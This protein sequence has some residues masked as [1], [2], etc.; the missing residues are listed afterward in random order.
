MITEQTD[1]IISGA[2][3]TGCTLAA[4]LAKQGISS[5]IIESSNSAFKSSSARKDPRILSLT[6][7]TKRILSSIDIWHQLPVGKIGGFEKIHIWDDDT[8]ADIVFNCSDVCAPALG[9]IVGQAVLQEVLE[10]LI[11][12]IPIINTMTGVTIA[13]YIEDDGMIN[14]ELSD[15]RVIKSRLLVGADGANSQI[16]NLAGIAVECIDYHQKAVA[17][18]VQTQIPHDKIARQRFLSTGPLAFLPMHEEN[19]CGVVWSTQSELADAL[20][21]LDDREFCLALEEAFESRL[22][23]VQRCE[24]RVGFK[25]HRNQALSYF[26]R[27]CVLVGDAAHTVHPLAGQGAN[28]GITD[29]AVLSQLL[30][31]AK[32]DDRM[33]VS[34]QV[35]RNYERWRKTEN[36]KMTLI[37]EGLKNFFEAENDLVSFI[38]GNGM[39]MINHS[40]FIK[41]RIMKYA[42]GL[43]G[44]VPSIINGP[45]IKEFI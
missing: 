30:Q 23:E 28:L 13:S 18:I 36:K 12:S 15:G 38:R 9:Y 1:I 11:N 26:N 45:L 34:R 35:L 19:Q 16:R 17:C 2:G 6:P 43:S 8:K 33:L 24:Q 44:D 25:L 39:M 41:N 27:L 32:L 5:T 31:Q 10:K 21:V 14:C 29:A 42:M 4:L 7:A 37:L 40:P 22:G 3:L 20:L